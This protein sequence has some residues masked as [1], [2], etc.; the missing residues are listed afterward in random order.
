VIF[1]SGS[2]GRPKGVVVEHGS[3]AF[4]LAA[5]QGVIGWGASDV[6]A[7]A[8]APSFDATFLELL[9]PLL[10]GGSCRILPP[11]PGA[12]LAAWRALLPDLTVLHAVPGLMRPLVNLAQAEGIPC[13]RLRTVLTG[14]EAVP[15][16]LLADLR[17]A[18]PAAALGVLYGPTEA[19]IICTAWIVPSGETPSRSVLGRPLPGVEILLRDPAGNAVPAG[20]VGE[21]WIGGP[22]VARGYLGLPEE[23]ATRFVEHGGRRFYRTGDR[24]RWTAAGELE[25][26]GRSDDQV[27][28]RGVRIEPGEVEAALAAAPGV[29]EAAVVV[30]EDLPGGGG[31]GGYVG[32]GEGSDLRAALARRLPAS[33]IP[34]AFVLLDRLPRTSA[35]KVDRRA[36]PPP[37]IPAAEAVPPRSP[38][39]D[40]L[41]G[42]FA[43]ILEVP[44]VP[45]DRG[46]FDLG[47]HSLL[48]TR[49]VSRIREVFRIELPLREVFEKPAAAA[50]AGAVEA[51]LREG[52]GLA[53]P[54]IRPVTREVD[55]PLSFAQ[56]RLWFL[57]RLQPGTAT[58]N[59]PLAVAFAGPLDPAALEA[60]LL[61]VVA[62]HEALRTR[63]PVS[64]EGQPVQRIAPPPEHILPR[65]DLDAL[66]GPEREAEARRLA[67]EEAARPFDLEHDLPLRACL[68]RRGPADHLAL[69]TLHHIASDAWSAGVLVRDLAALYRGEAL[70]ELP[71]QY[72]DFA[73]W[74]REWLAGEA[75]ERQLAFWR[76]RLAGAPPVLDL[77]F[78]RP[79]PAVQTFR[80]GQ[81]SIRL[82]DGPAAAAL[83]TLGRSAGTTLFM[84]LLAGFAVWLHRLTGA[85]D[86]VV[87]TPHANRG[88]AEVEDL[89]GF[90]VNTLALR[91]DLSGDP[92]FRDLLRRVREGSLAAFAA[93]DLPFEKLVS[94]LS[95]DRHLSHAPLVQVL[96]QLLEL[97][98]GP[99]P[100]LDGER[101]LG[102]SFEPQAGAPTAEMD[103]VVSLREAPDGLWG[104]WRFTADLL[105]GSTVERLAGHLG[106]LLQA[107]VV[108]PGT[109]LADLPLLTAAERAQILLEWNPPAGEPSAEAF[110]DLL[111]EQAARI[112]DAPAVLTDDREVS[113]GELAVLTRRGAAFLRRRGVGPESVVVLVAERGLGLLVGILAVQKAGGAWLPLDPAW[114]ESRL[115]RMLAASGAIVIPVEE[116]LNAGPEPA[117]S[118]FFGAG[119]DPRNLAYLIATSGS[120]GEP[121]A[122]M[123]E[124]RG[125]LNHLRSKAAGLGLT[126]ADTVAQTASHTFDISVW[127]SLAPL[128]AG[129]RVRL[130]PDAVVRDPALLLEAVARDGVTVLEVVPSLL[131]G[132][133]DRLETAGMPPPPLRWLISTGEALPPELA[134]RWLAACPGIPLLNAYG[135]SEASDRVSQ[136]RVTELPPWG[137]GTPIGRPLPNLRLFVLDRPERG[138]GPVP[139][140]AAGE[141]AIGGVGVGRGY[142]GDPA[143]TAEVFVPDPSA[144]L[145][146]DL[147]ARL[148]RTGDLARFR[149]DGN[150]E[151]LGRRDHQVKVRGYRIEAG[152]VETALATLPGVRE[153]AVAVRQGRLT[154]WVVLENSAADLRASLKEL[155]P[156]YMVPAAFVKLAALPR[157][158]NGKVDRRALPEPDGAVAAAGREA[159]RTPLERL[160]AGLWQEVIGGEG[161]I[162]VHDSFF[163]LGGDS[164]K[165]A[166]F[167]NRLGLRLGEAVPVA[168]LFESPTL[169][170]LA[171]A[172][173]A[174]YPQAVERTLAGEGG[175]S[176]APAVLMPSL[177]GRQPLSF[178]QE[179]LWFLHQLDPE[180][181]TYNMAQALALRGRLDAGALDR[182]FSE[183]VRRHEI[184][185]T[186]YAVREGRPFAEAGPPPARVLDRVDLAGLPAPAAEARRLL[187]EA[188][189]RPFDLRRGPLVRAL[190]V[191]LGPE[192]HALLFSTHHIAGDGWSLGLWAREVEILYTAFAAGRPSP[193]PELPMQ[194]ADFAAWQR[195]RL[196]GGRLET[197]VA[198]WRER[199]RDAPPYLE[200]P[201]DHPRPAFQTYR[202]AGASLHLPA[203]LAD[204]L[205]AL[206]G[207]HN[208]SLFMTLLA[209]F[210][211]HLRRLSGQEDVLVGS[212]IA[213]RTRPE[214]EGLIGCFLNTLALRCDLSGD[215]TFLDLL[216]RVRGTALGAFSHQDVPFEKLLEEL[217]PERDTSRPSLFQVLFNMLNAPHAEMELPGLELAPLGTGELFAK[218]DL[219]LYVS[220]GDGLGLDLVYNA[221]LFDAPRM[222]EMLR[223]YSLLLEQIAARPEAPAGSYSLLTAEAAAVLPDP[224]AS[225]FHPW[226]G[227]VHDLFAARARQAPEKVALVDRD[228]T[229]TYGELDRAVD[230]LAARLRADGISP[231]DRVAVYAHRGASLAWALLAIL[232]AGAGFTLLDPI[233]P[234]P[235]LIDRLK[236]AEPR[237][238]LWMEGAGPM[239]RDLERFVAAQR[240]PCRLTLPAGPVERAAAPFA[241]Q[242]LPADW[243]RRGPYDVA[244]VAFTSGSTGLPKGIVQTH[245]SMSYFLPWHQEAL[246]FTEA[247]RHTLLSGLAH[248]PLQ[249]DIFYCLATGGILCIPDPDRIGAPGYLA[250]WMA[251]QRVTVSNMTPA[252]GRLLTEL[253]PGA[254]APVL[255]DL[256]VAILAGDLLT[257]EGVERIRALAPGAVFL[258]VYGT[259]ESQRALSYHTVEQ[260]RGRRLKQTLPLG[261]GKTGCQILV[262]TPAGGRAGI[263]EI[264]EVVI[265][266]PHLARGYLADEAQNRAKLGVNPFTGEPL[267]RLYRTGDLGRYLPDGDVEAAGRADQQVKIRGF[268]VEPGE[269][270]AELVR[271]PGVKEAV[272]V[273][274]QRV[275]EGERELAAYVVAESGFMIDI[276]DVRER[277]RQSLPAYM[278]P[279][280]WVVLP[281][282]PVN[283]NGKIDRLALPAPE[284]AAAGETAG[285]PPRDALE[286][287]LAAIWEDVLGIRPVGVT[288]DFF[289]LGGH[290][291]L[292]ARLMA[293]IEAEL[294]RALPLSALFQGG[295]VEGLAERLRAAAPEE[296]SPLVPLQRKGSRPPLFLVHPAGGQVLCYAG[297]VRRLGEDRPIYGLQDAGS[298]EKERAVADL[299]AVYVEKVLETQPE[300]PVHLA[301]WSFGGRVAF[302]MACQLT[303]KNREVA[304]L[305]LLDAGR[306]RAD[307]ASGAEEADEAALLREVLWFVPR[308]ALEG[309]EP[310]AED[311][312]GQVLG[313]LRDVGSLPDGFE[314]EQARRL[315]RTFREHLEMARRDRPRFWPGRLAFFAA[316]QNPGGE[317]SPDPTHGWAAL[318]AAVEVHRVPG[319]HVSMIYDEASLEIL[320][321]FLRAAL[322]AS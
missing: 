311:P 22:G 158:R 257:R 177:S 90:F 228:G 209:A 200:L 277:L 1:T 174:L 92:D 236:M 32:G 235:R 120:T 202:G 208:A 129:G 109:R 269:V 59:V 155:L 84:T 27:K 16:E 62:R 193:L 81:R 43:E 199:L 122:V 259:T 213:G 148:Y 237:G 168:R 108:E 293:R 183:V 210:A 39:E 276:P 74:Q 280:A 3:L 262:L 180:G 225:V 147:G 242:P 47:G 317:A 79:R 103:L 292:A 77:P 238:L 264:G 137:A 53:A 283:P 172:L 72:A 107:A 284:A 15:A 301:G 83:R 89:I 20:A 234:A 24:A 274:R 21:I 179:R 300:G 116:V 169:A 139:V 306:V 162:G 100:S 256:R 54:P 218:L 261:R 19:T 8:A 165:G 30:R 126:A 94:H 142:R 173:E 140:G 206:S 61:G 80:G 37:P 12:D 170:A 297:L 229:W 52:Q 233:Y 5:A 288:D 112:P 34:A 41:A 113:Y 71:V 125:M 188:A 50:L 273:A 150:L 220:E 315:W 67:A 151:L 144:D 44:A 171:A 201:L 91:Q 138:L 286:R 299:A 152:E 182:A 119:L 294:G 197:Q 310:G 31:L 85:G 272:V 157:N 95:P 295:T 42:L 38:V 78:D 285:V 226:P 192:S 105:D 6:T 154:A 267:D 51:R 156:A 160:L 35:G 241:D 271:A 275:P 141:L 185:R 290:S 239:T 102:V 245:G 14:G 33:M 36:L 223:Q 76:E 219:T 110:P 114:P 13:L 322:E 57:E 96:F 194:Y 258:N 48:A 260:D 196:Q 49:L 115:R 64:P 217:R 240:Y 231:D 93:S 319:D 203:G 250:A 244:S 184:L 204:R 118:A 316:E 321:R 313:R 291:L 153:A 176:A 11:G 46:F 98:S 17:R 320:A 4:T 287:R 149:A 101:R 97:P 249:R 263:G 211:L 73:V 10:A 187:R 127:Q 23:T 55:P 255:E 75:L 40:L 63:F 227:A 9:A 161:A 282:L 146:E 163:D 248:D 70:P 221:D 198:Y 302:E 58:Y 106:T 135:P 124:H 212:P 60:A 66:P 247:D 143:R 296:D 87:G 308:E 246:G 136:Y 251:E 2:T 191:R 207:R 289:D 268:R 215:P 7:W 121:K 279:T 314:P 123:V 312:L 68:V 159:P 303:L 28:I 133:L 65:V 224:A 298:A 278:V 88:R 181:A 132:L 304:F 253:P 189:L 178:A 281:K 252:M 128:L 186:V 130:Y 214:A 305:G 164:I 26:R 265:R 134:R 307:G 175:G 25:F 243:P 82:A 45:L 190:L 104:E 166:I 318:A 29:R 309:L 131:A 195:D 86:L 56:E 222:E 216:R 117:A 254:P 230:R 270:E 205:R 232:K 167:T 99:V 111:E 69:L 18:F 266:S 145:R